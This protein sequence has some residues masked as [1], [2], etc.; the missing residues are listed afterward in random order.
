MEYFRRFILAELEKIADAR[1]EYQEE[2]E[3]HKEPS[4]AP[5]PVKKIKKK[6]KL[7][8]LK[9]KSRKEIIEK[10]RPLTNNNSEHEEDDPEQ[11]SYSEKVSHTNPLL[12]LASTAKFA[13]STKAPLGVKGNAK[14][15]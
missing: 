3:E 5:T 4:I 13:S 7:R 14:T 8:P 15:G 10:V 9:D 1:E 2:V 11:E 12:I 6:G